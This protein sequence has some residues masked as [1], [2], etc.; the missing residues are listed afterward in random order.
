M[1]DT[2][3]LIDTGP[4]GAAYNMALDEAIATAARRD[5]G[6]PTLRFYGW[7]VPS[8][9]VGCFQKISDIDI[10]YCNEKHF[11]IIRRSTGGRAILHNNELTYSFSVKTTSGPF[12]KGLL[13][14]YKKISE[15]LCSALSMTG[16]TPKLKLQ[17]ETRHPQTA[18]HRT[19]SPLCFQSTSYCEITINNKKVVGSAQKRW[20]DGLLQQGSIPFTVNINEIVKTFRLGYAHDIIETFTGLKVISPELKPDDLKNAIRTSFEE[21]FDT[22]LITSPLSREEGS[23]A[24]ELEAQKYLSSKWTFRR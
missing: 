22:S 3:R 12:S 24:Q 15:A 6:P 2:W 21:I 18:R 20:I 11:P 17:K 19:G 4:C 10:E 1:I 8:V 5:Y 7:D 14:S 13:D 9:T 23:L 16:L